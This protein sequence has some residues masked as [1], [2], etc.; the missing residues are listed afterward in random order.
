MHSAA[1]GKS[2]TAEVFER[3]PPGGDEDDRGHDEGHQRGRI[4]DA[5]VE[6]AGRDD[7]LIEE[8]AVKGE[9][10]E[11][12][13]AFR[14]VAGRPPAGTAQDLQGQPRRRRDIEYDRGQ[15]DRQGIHERSGGR[16]GMMTDKI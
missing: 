16:A 9:G 1:S 12:E 7:A 11:P 14:R 2:T 4:E 13:Q 6:A 3:P 10:E 8:E 5:E 15:A